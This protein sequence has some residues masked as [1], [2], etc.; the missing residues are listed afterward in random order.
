VDTKCKKCNYIFNY[1]KTPEAGM[2]W[3]KCPK[4]GG[5]VTQA[6]KVK[7]DEELSI[8]NLD[9]DDI[10]NMDPSAAIKLLELIA[11]KQWRNKGETVKACVSRKISIIYHEERK[12]PVGKRKTREQIIGEA[13][14]MCEK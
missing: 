13:Y 4:C 5:P 2:G 8:F 11:D 3:V 14:G 7:K 1:D 12:K 6:D 9:T 10:Y